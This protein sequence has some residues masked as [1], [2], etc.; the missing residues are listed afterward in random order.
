ME[1][2]VPVGELFDIVNKARRLA[3]FPNNIRM[4]S[5]RKSKIISDVSDLDYSIN[6][7]SIVLVDLL[8][9]TSPKDDFW[10]RYKSFELEILNLYLYAFICN[11]EFRRPVYYKFNIKNNKIYLASLH[12]NVRGY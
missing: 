12:L 7:L 2:N 9:E 8:D 6:D 1:K 10:A 4:L 3:I 5:R 11:D